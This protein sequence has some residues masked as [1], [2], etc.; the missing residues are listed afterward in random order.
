MPDAPPRPEH[1]DLELLIAVLEAE[2]PEKVLKVGF[3]RPHSYRGD[4]M[5]L[6]FEIAAD[7]TVGAMLADARS[8]LGTTYEGWKGGDY[9]MDDSTP[10]WLVQGRG[11]CGESIGAVL[12]HLLLANVTEP[13]FQT[14]DE[15]RSW[16]RSIVVPVYGDVRSVGALIATTGEI[17]HPS[18][19]GG[20][21]TLWDRFE[22]ARRLLDG[23][24]RRG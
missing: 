22:T 12:L 5:D 14:A 11:D 16:L 6:A 23:E 1:L 8:A 9:T 2:D 3:H 13:D 7:I 20:D 4:Y 24:A 17:V 21:R 19:H 15:A 18:R 10:V